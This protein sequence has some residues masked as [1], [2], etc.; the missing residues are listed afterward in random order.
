[1]NVLLVYPGVTYMPY[2]FL[3]KTLLVIVLLLDCTEIPAFPHPQRPEPVKLNP[4]TI[5]LF[6]SIVSVLPEP[7]AFTI[8]C[9]YISDVGVIN[10]TLN[11]HDVIASRFYYDLR[12]LRCAHDQYQDY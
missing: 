7:D 5:V 9:D 4:F 11:G 1:M 10:S 2:V 12:R 8:G 3:Y 6:D